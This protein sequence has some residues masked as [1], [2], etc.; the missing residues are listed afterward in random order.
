MAVKAQTGKAINKFSVR[1]SRIVEEDGIGAF[2][3]ESVAYKGDR[4]RF[5]LRWAGP[6]KPLQ[7]HE[8]W[9]RAASKGDRAVVS[10]RVEKVTA[11]EETWFGDLAGSI[12]KIKGRQMILGVWLTDARISR[13]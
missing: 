11:E 13:P 6:I 8:Q 3:E 1:I 10:G 7:G 5:F 9:L 4:Y 2:I 12:D